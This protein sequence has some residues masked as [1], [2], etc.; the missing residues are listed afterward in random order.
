M[1][2][3][4][5]VQK[6]RNVFSYQL[7]TH[8]QRTQNH[9]QTQVDSGV[10]AA[11]RSDTMIA[12]S[13]SE[14]DATPRLAGSR[15]ARA[16]ANVIAE[17]TMLGIVIG[18]MIPRRSVNLPSSTTQR[19]R[20][21]PLWR[22]KAAQAGRVGIERAPD[23]SP[24]DCRDAVADG[25]LDTSTVILLPRIREATVLSSRPTITLAEL[26]LGPERLA[27]LRRGSE[28]QAESPRRVPTM[29]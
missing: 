6:N 13:K 19:L 2:S 20:H 22:V 1:I 26:S 5:G 28:Q 24:C 12:N 10:L 17:P 11:V 25:I 21:E 7:D 16:R 27:A 8:A 29:R 18:F 9:L 3:V 23:D 4:V 14:C 15:E